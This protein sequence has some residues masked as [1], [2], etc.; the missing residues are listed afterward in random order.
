MALKILVVDD[1]KMVRTALARL[2]SLHGEWEVVGEA[3][4][5]LEAIEK[6]KKLK[7]DVVIMDITMPAMNG[8]EATP[9]IKKEIP[10]AEVLILSQHHSEQILREAQNAGAM[11]YL[12]KS[13]ANWLTVAVET[14]SEH[15]PFFQGK[16]IST[17]S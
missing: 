5:G 15:K 1:E 4:D 16:N 12:L 17:D 3:S 6:A 8:L 9:I 11:G 2:L 7:P 14:V 13:H 10:A